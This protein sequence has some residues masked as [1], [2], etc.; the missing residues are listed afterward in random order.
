MVLFAAQFLL[1]YIA[2]PLE[3]M[4]T[5]ASTWRDQRTTNGCARSATHSRVQKYHVASSN[6][7]GGLKHW[8]WHEALDQIEGHHL[9]MVLFQETG[10]HTLAQKQGVQAA[11]HSAALAR[12]K[13]TIVRLTWNDTAGKTGHIMALATA[14]WTRTTR[15]VPLTKLGLRRPERI[16]TDRVQVILIQLHGKNVHVIHVYGVPNDNTNTTR[17]QAIL[18]GWLVTTTK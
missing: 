2:I 10:I 1:P 11:I 12:T 17:I 3:E 5:E 14:G 6:V 4:Q 8:D 18:T 9:N 15:Q 16:V 7:R 13:P